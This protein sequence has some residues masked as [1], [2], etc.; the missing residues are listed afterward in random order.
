M[1]AVLQKQCRRK[2][3]ARMMERDPLRV[4]ERFYEDGYLNDN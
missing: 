1:F 2:L 3:A 4:V